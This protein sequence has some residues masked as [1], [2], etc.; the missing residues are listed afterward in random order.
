M[1]ESPN[2]LPKYYETGTIARTAERRRLLEDDLVKTWRHWDPYLCE[3]HR[4][5]VREWYKTDN[6]TIFRLPVCRKQCFPLV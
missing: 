5:T 3:R 1:G 6:G 4:G 2:E